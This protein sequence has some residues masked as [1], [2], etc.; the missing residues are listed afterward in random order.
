MNN[1][2]QLAST[3]TNV[4]SKVVKKPTSILRTGPRINRKLLASKK[5][6]NTFQSKEDMIE[7]V[8]RLT[9]PRGHNK[10]KNEMIQSTQYYNKF[11]ETPVGPFRKYLFLII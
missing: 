7:S 4:K 5:S 9:N 6:T 1:N 8:S 10:N 11:D 3:C 2:D